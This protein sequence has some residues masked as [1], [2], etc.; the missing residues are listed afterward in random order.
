M[1]DEFDKR[2]RSF[3]WGDIHGGQRL[4]LV[5]WSQLC[6]LINQDGLGLKSC[7]S[8]NL[9]FL[10]KLEWRILKEY[11]ALWVQALK[12]KYFHSMSNLEVFVSKPIS[13]FIWRG[14]VNIIAQRSI[15]GCR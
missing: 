1:C 11:H 13:S 10:A 9:T 2:I 7:Q 4:Y 15:Y 12:G 3:F 14:V 6:L 5:N 8:M